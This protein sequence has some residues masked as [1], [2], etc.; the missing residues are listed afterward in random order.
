V[1]RLL[2]A[3]LLAGVTLLGSGSAAWA[4]DADSLA[5]RLGE[6]PVL[7]DPRSGIRIDEDAVRDAFEALAVPTYV[8][9]VP[10]RDVDEE[11]TGIDGVLLRVV[12][13]LDDPRAV[14]VVVTDAGELQAGEGGASGVQASALLD[15][16][17][18]ARSEQ[19]FSGQALTE[20]LLEF[21]VGV[22]GGSD[23]GAE[24]GVDLLD[25]QTV[26]VAGLVGVA[27]VA[28]GMLWMRSQRQVRRQAPLTDAEPGGG[29]W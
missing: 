24:R 3:S 8:V 9:I 11:E 22:D 14:V 13:A 6:D 26:G 7:V 19:A 17:V 2:L 5:E 1:T 16:I 18:Q 25:P 12:E 4:V 21:A 10:Q 23:E 29:S 20:A 28:A 27:V 15:R